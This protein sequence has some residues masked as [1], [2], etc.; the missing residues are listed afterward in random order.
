MMTLI[1]AFV[2][3]APP[4]LMVALTLK[5]ERINFT[6]YMLL[7]VGYTIAHILSVSQVIN[8]LKELP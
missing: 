6:K 5:M 4:S 7:N 2:L 1:L 8:Y 3:L